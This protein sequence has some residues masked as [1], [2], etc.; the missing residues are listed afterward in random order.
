MK[1]THQI[2][3][4][5]QAAAM[6]VGDSEVSLR[7][8]YGAKEG[9]DQQTDDMKDWQSLVRSQSTKDKEKFPNRDTIELSCTTPL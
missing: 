5:D 6:L 2:P 9:S 3:L 1:E 7:A 4:D 8:L